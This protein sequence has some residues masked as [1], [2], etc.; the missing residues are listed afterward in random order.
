MGGTLFGMWPAAASAR[1]L[2]GRRLPLMASY[3]DHA[4]AIAAA[5]AP[6]ERITVVPDPPQTPM[7]HLL[8]AAPVDVVDAGIR[9]LAEQQ[10]L[11]TWPATMP[12][13]D[14]GVQR[15]ELSVGDATCRLAPDEV[16][17]ALAEL[18]R[19]G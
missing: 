16:A 5:L 12:T 14:P 19:E 1:S 15:V 6:A 2:L 8:L 13:V 17:A 9:R 4:R 11:W 7:L 10:S 3:L 18:V